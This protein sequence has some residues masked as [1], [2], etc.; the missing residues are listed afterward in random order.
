MIAKVPDAIFQRFFRGWDERCQP[1]QVLVNDFRV[2]RGCLAMRPQVLIQ[3]SP[4][5]M[6]VSKK[7][8]T[9]QILLGS[10]LI[11]KW[12]NGFR[13]SKKE[14]RGPAPASACRPKV[15]QVWIEDPGRG[16]NIVLKEIDFRQQPCLMFGLPGLLLWM[17]ASRQ[18]CP[19]LGNNLCVGLHDF[20]CVLWFCWDARQYSIPLF[21]GNIRHRQTWPCPVGCCAHDEIEEQIWVVLN[22]VLSIVGV[23]TG[24]V[25]LDIV[26]RLM[27]AELCENSLDS[28]GPMS[29]GHVGEKSACLFLVLQDFQEIIVLHHQGVLCMVDPWCLSTE[30]NPCFIIPQSR[31]WNSQ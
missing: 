23:N 14:K 12:W 26:Q 17:A 5:Q 27:R 31:K 22:R 16:L 11:Q 6:F 7:S 8:Q 20:E 9:W 2:P 29:V 4:R 24:N 13:D 1:V 21:R 3:R 28:S 10:A 19:R 15:Q 25:N 18:R 30:S